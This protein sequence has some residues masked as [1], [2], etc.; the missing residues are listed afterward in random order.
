MFSEE[1]RVGDSYKKSYSHNEVSLACVLGTCSV[2]VIGGVLQ[3]YANATLDALFFSLLLFLGGFLVCR[4]VFGN[5]TSETRAF[6]LTCSLCLFVGGLAQ[7]YALLAFGQLQTTVDAIGFFDAI[8]SGPP[9]YS[10]EELNSLTIDG[11]PVSRGAP[12]AVALWQW[13]YRF[14]ESTG[15]DFGLYIGVM[16]N[17]VVVGVS[18][19]V[20][21][22]TAREL[23]GD[24]DWRLNRVGTLYAFCGLT[25]LFGALFL[26]DCFTTFLNSIVLLSLVRLVKAPGKGRLVTAIAVTSVAIYA[27]SFLRE[28]SIVLFGLYW[29]LA[30]V[31]WLFQEPFRVDR[32][33]VVM[34]AGGGALVMAPEIQRY[35]DVSRG[36]QAEN[37]ESYSGK[38]TER[39]DEDSLALALI[40]NQPLPVRII[41]GT[42]SRMVFP[43]PL[44]AYFKNKPSEYHLIK[45]YHG[46]YQVV[47][48]PLLLTGAFLFVGQVMQGAR[49]HL[50]M[51]F[52]VLYLLLNTAAVMSTSLE[53][54]HLAQFMAAFF[55]LAAIPDT[56]KK[57]VK[58]LLYVVGAGWI[59]TVVGV[60]VAWLGA[61]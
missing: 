23:F 38:L 30:I 36:L 19:A 51:M 27:I 33:A 40:V 59:M 35:I 26:R 17:S 10:W 24:D 13:A 14:L 34:I 41:A 52:V 7:V 48:M 58:S 37:L 9:F 45:G 8:S 56:R 32:L 21:V 15:F 55:V 42:A 49:P 39:S 29:V 16:V 5:A 2:A 20:A 53:Q 57:S 12:L 60:H 1:G 54:R 4:G 61:K 25:W 28:K 44:W 22:R 47:V 43:I 11:F 46:I 50:P 18:A 6:S 3:S 31:C